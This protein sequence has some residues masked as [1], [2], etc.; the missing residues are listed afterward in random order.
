[1]HASNLTLSQCEIATSPFKMKAYGFTKENVIERAVNA[2]E[3]AKKHRLRV[4]FFAVDTTRAEE[5]FLKQIY[6]TA[7]EEAHADE[8]V[9]ADTLGVALPEA[10]Y[11]LTR[12]VKSWVKVPV[13]IHCHNEFGLA[14]ACSLTAV[15]AGA[16]WIHVSVNGIGERSGNTD[17]AEIALALLLL[18]NKDIGIKYGS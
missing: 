9:I 16:E 11:H 12:K 14:T 5:S 10:I 6:T 8:V 4:A 18:Y 1:M 7:V 17:I 13:H 15:K 3:Y 2:I